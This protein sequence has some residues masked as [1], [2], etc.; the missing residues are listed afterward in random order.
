MPVDVNT[1]TT[2]AKALGLSGDITN[3]LL[4]VVAILQTIHHFWPDLT[5]AKIIAMFQPKPPAPPVK[6]A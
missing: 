3:G 5:A 6:P 4:F 1:L 2:A